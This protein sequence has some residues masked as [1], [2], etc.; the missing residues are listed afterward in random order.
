MHLRE[1]HVLKLGTHLHIWRAGHL[2]VILGGN[3]ALCSHIHQQT[4]GSRAL[5][6]GKRTRIS[7]GS[8]LFLQQ[9]QQ[10]IIIIKQQ[11]VII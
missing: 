3:L 5:A 2:P 9:Q 7:K 11:L 10:L 8:N 6:A 4:F 1:K